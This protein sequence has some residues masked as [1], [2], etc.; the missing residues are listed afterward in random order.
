MH[1]IRHNETEEASLGAGWP[2]GIT[3]QEGDGLERR[4]CSMFARRTKDKKGMLCAQVL[5]ITLQ[6]NPFFALT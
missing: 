4:G 2:S 3:G 1:G 5:C 6:S